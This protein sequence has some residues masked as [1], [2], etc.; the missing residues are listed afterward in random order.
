MYI[1]LLLA[2]FA[3]TAT[4]AVQNEGTQVFRLLGYGWTL[5]T[6]APT[7][8]AVGVVTAVLVL[9][10][11][12]LGLRAHLRDLGHGREMERHVRLIEDLL[13]ENVLLREQVAGLQGE[14]RGATAPPP[15]GTGSG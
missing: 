10:A 14:V 8:I 1:V 9:V 2:I 4:F 6:W 3:L 15:P 12:Y 13:A 5:P 7:A 11:A